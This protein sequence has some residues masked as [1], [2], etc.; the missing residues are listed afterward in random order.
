MPKI[1]PK[2]V[3]ISLYSMHMD[4]LVDCRD[5]AGCVAPSVDGWSLP[6]SG[7]LPF[8]YTH[9]VGIHT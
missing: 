1:H 2:H 9:I 5:E 3:C 7:I 8:C 6:R 4:N